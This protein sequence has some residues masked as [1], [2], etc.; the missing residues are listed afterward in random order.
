LTASIPTS[1]A[2]MA[3][4]AA[5]LASSVLAFAIFLGFGLLSP[6]RSHSW[7]GDPGTVMAAAAIVTI[8]APAVAL[9]PATVLG[10][11]VERPKAKKMIACRGG[12]FIWHVFLSVLAAAL[13]S[14]LLRVALH[15]TN[16]MY[17]LLDVFSL[18]GF[19]LIGLCSGISWWFFVV[20]PGRRT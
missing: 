7:I 1:R 2:F 8:W 9:I 20:I 14:L 6:G 17:P 10:L 3:I 13:L 12:G 11:L 16:P 4:L 15:L 19:S 5:S 18:A